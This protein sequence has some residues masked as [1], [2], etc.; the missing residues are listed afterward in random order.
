MAVRRPPAGRVKELS[1][2]GDQKV[3][4]VDT[5]DASLGQTIEI[6]GGVWLLRADFAHHDRFSRLVGCAD[7][8]GQGVRGP[9]TPRSTV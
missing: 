8:H 5:V 2:A 7:R 4:V 1:D 9:P 3:Y 6:P